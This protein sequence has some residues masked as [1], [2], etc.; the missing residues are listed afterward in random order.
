MLRSVELL[1]FRWAVP[2]L[3]GVSSAEDGEADWLM[4]SGEGRW[5]VRLSGRWSGESA[6]ILDWTAVRELLVLPESDGGPVG[7]L[8]GERSGED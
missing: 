4:C 7:N 8:N 2:G 6:E 3:V 1:E 5:N